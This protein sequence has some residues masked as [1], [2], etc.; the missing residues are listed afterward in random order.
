MTANDCEVAF[1]TVKQVPMNLMVCELYLVKALNIQFD[2]FSTNILIPYKKINLYDPEVPHE[3][4]C[5]KEM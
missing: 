5:S 3:G 2:N 4:I 1:G